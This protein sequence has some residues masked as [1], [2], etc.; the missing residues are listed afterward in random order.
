MMTESHTSYI[1]VGNPV[2]QVPQSSLLS[3]HQIERNFHLDPN[4]L[5]KVVLYL[6]GQ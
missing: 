6:I 2:L 3:S 4:L 5:V 1:E